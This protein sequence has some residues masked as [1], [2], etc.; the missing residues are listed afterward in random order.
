[1]S[2]GF[3]ESRLRHRRQRRLKVLKWLVVVGF[4]VGL[5]ALS[6]K[7]GSE[8]AKQE[9]VHLQKEVE[10]RDRTIEGFVKDMGKLKAEL[11]AAKLRER[12][13]RVRYERDVPTA[14][15][16]KL[17]TMI[18][19]RLGEG[20]RSDRLAFV[21]NNVA[22]K[23]NCDD[24]SVTRRFI[25]QTPISAGA[26]GAVSFAD[27]TITVTAEGVSATD[28]VGKPEAWFDAAKPVSVHFTR[29]GGKTTN[30]SGV[31]PVH[32]SIAVAG[33]E[34]AFTVTDGDTRGFV[35][36]SWQRCAYP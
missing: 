20:I 23:R 31:L 9:V 3:R 14:V 19:R 30:V 13:L 33:T 6:Y 34:H 25:V 28:G 1:M 27:N 7:S 17:L 32:H 35:K 22:N 24:R 26:H 11:E 15:R 21:I 10:R 36:V 8:L 16:K 4:F 12:D 2:S 5:G 18:D 29:I